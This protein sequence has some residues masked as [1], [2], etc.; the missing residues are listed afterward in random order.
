MAFSWQESTVSAGTQN[1]PCDIEYLDKSYIHVYLDGQETTAFSWT[2]DTVIRLDA[3]L[4]AETVVLLIR[5]TE[6]EYL[7]IMFASGAPFIESNVDT[8]NTQFLHLAQELVEG[9]SIEGFYGD[10]NMHRY[11]ITNLGDP[12][13]ARDAAN[14]QYVD[15]GD[16]RLSARI[17][18]ETA[19]RKAADAA[20]DVRTTNLEQTFFNANTNSFPWWTILTVDTDTVTPGMPFTKA[21]VR[22]Q[23]ATQT[24]G[25]SY[26][27]V[28]NSIVF[29]EVL[30]AGTLIDATIGIDTDADTSAASIILGLLASSSGAGYIG[31]EMGVNVAEALSL[32]RIVYPEMFAGA[33]ADASDDAVFAAMFDTLAAREDLELSNDIPYTIDLR[34]KVYTLTQTHSIDANINM[35]NGT[36]LM[37]GGQIVLGNELAGSKT[38]RHTIVDLKVRYVGSTYYPDALFKIARAFNTFIINSDFW[39]GTSQELETSGTYVGKPKR[40]RYALWLGSR[41]VWGSSIIGGDFYGGEVPCRV[42]YTNDH[43]GITLAGGSTYHHG[44][45]GNLMACNLAGSLIAGINVEHS[46]NGAWG[47]GL[48]SGTNAALGVVNAAHGV[49]IAGLYLYNNGNGSDGSTNAPA[50]VLVGVDLPGTTGF[51]V[52]GALITSQNTAHSITIRN[53]YIVSPKQARAVVMRGLASLVVENCKYTYASGESYGFRFEGTAATSACL[54]NRNQSSGLFDEVEYTSTNAPRMRERT[55]TFLP[56]LQGATT[57]GSLTYSTRGGD[58]SISGNQCRLSLWLV[59][60]AV[61]TAPAGAL[62]IELPIAIASGR[63]SATAVSHINLTGSRSI[64]TTGTSETDVTVTG[65]LDSDAGATLTA[66]GTGSGT[67][68]GTVSIPNALLSGSARIISGSTLTLRLGDAAMPGSVITAGS[69]IALCI[70]YPI[71]GA[72]YTGT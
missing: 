27:I 58:Y 71:A 6:R 45:V 21:K 2:S 15:A 41:R 36:L 3:A 39:G 63:R 5:K 7:Y 52:A 72:T 48:T 53:C 20:L 67:T 34:G 60:G 65:A 62:S 69:D 18:A 70:E 10:I 51:D 68:T 8:Q 57:A 50:A 61:N 43:T 29:A 42:G 46:E 23:G 17:D 32:G 19:A 16:A 64:A 24:A 44:Y 59:V 14:K 56:Q 37:N 40:A 1:I 26:N 12:V 25:Y 49:D 38:R 55:G 28:D 33:A 9:R 54:Y 66:T 31:T 22:V 47:L 4:T 35:K 30:P 11:R 13:D